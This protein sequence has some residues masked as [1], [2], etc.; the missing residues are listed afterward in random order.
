MRSGRNPVMTTMSPTP[1]SCAVAIVR[2][3]S[4]RPATVTSGLLS[5]PAPIRVPGPAAKMMQ[6]RSARSDRFSAP[7]NAACSVAIGSVIP[8]IFP[9]VSGVR[10]F[11]GRVD[12]VFADPRPNVDTRRSVVAVDLRRSLVAAARRHVQSGSNGSARAPI[13]SGGG[14]GFRAR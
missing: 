4:A 9:P 6:L 12:P 5:T 11:S 8:S 2:S 3:S 10:F 14:F 7:F 1:A 13:P